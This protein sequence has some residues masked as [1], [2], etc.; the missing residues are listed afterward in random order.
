MHTFGSTI[1]IPGVFFE[2]S[3]FAVNATPP[4]LYPAEQ[5]RLPSLTLAADTPS[6]ML[7][8]PAAAS[9]AL[10]LACAASSRNALLAAE[11]DFREPRNTACKSRICF[12]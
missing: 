8:K 9:A 1:Q 4:S 6:R 12:S 11:D 7:D 2:R 10:A 5:S 3:T